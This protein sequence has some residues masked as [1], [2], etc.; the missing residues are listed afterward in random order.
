VRFAL[1][2][3]NSDPVIVMNGDSY[4]DADLAA[5][6]Q[7]H[8]TRQA[9]ASVLLTRVDAA[10]RYGQVL[11]DSQQRVAAFR[12]KASSPGAGWINAGIYIVAHRLLESIPG[13]RAV[14]LEREV[15]PT[16]VGG[17]FYGH[18]CDARFIDIGTPESYALAASFLAARRSA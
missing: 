3:L 5:F 18:R 16:W 10:D 17:R 13:G 6:W 8:C 15:F 7:F 2:R 14:S 4:C 12:E 11:L 9:D 1:S